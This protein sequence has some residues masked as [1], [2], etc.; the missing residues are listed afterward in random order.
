MKKIGAYLGRFNPLH[1]AHEQVIGSMVEEYGEKNSLIIIG[2]AN[3]PFSLRHFFSYEERR[4]FIKTLFPNIKVISL[5]DFGNDR[6]W[7]LALDDI[8]SLGSATQTV[9]FG[10]CEED[11]STLIDG[12]KTC[13]IFN[14]F[15]GTTPKISATEI[16]DALIYGRPLEGLVNP[17]IAADIQKLFSQKWERF[18]KI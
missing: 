13:H 11:V 2:S 15:D 6:E 10:G 16:R 18:K 9:F 8:I 7:L 12:G 17:R 14:R 1:C 3:A 4:A 5:P